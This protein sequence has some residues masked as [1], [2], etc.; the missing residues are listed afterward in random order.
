[1]SAY[2]TQPTPFRALVVLIAAIAI[3]SL[4]CLFLAAFNA[5]ESSD[6]LRLLSASENRT[7]AGVFA[8]VAVLLVIVWGAK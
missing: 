1:M 3:V 8:C 5:I 4:Y 7:L 2:L 6:R